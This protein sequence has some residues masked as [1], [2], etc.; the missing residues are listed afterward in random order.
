MLDRENLRRAD[1]YS[2]WQ[3]HLP[4]HI[5]E[6]VI[7]KGQEEISKNQTTLNVIVRNQ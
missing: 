2:I 7:L 4:E 6:N 3:R 1:G 5:L